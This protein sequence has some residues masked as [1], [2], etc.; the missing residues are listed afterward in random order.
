MGGIDKLINGR[1][2][3]LDANSSVTTPMLYNLPYEDLIDWEYAYGSL[4][5]GEY[6]IVKKIYQTDNNQEY[7]IYTCFTIE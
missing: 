6:R 5:A 7:D 2:Y 3:R 4:E 1:W